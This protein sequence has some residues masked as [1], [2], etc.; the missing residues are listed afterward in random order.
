[1]S[2]ELQLQCSLRFSALAACSYDLTESGTE[3]APLLQPEHMVICK[4]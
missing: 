3:I 4:L 2:S 1:M